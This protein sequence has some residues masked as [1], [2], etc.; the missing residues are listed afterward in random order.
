[1]QMR[2]EDGLQGN[3]TGSTENLFGH[4]RCTP[5]LS[6]L[7]VHAKRGKEAVDDLV[8]Y[9]G[10]LVSDFWSSYV[11]LSCGHVFCGAHLLRELDYLGTILNLPWAS[12]L[13]LLFEKAVSACH[14]ARERGNPLF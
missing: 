7:F 4:V 9:Q 8:D 2:Q 14:R 5:H 11:K 1:M 12:K 6:W 10:T 3:Y 13:K